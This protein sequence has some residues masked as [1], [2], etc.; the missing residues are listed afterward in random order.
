MAEARHN[1]A[2]GRQQSRCRRGGES[3]SE[4]FSPLPNAPPLQWG[5]VSRPE[6]ISGI[7]A[8]YRSGNAFKSQGK[9]ADAI[10]CYRRAIALKPD[11]VEALNNLGATLKDQGKFGEAAACYR[12]ALKYQPDYAEAHSNLGGVFWE[13]GDLDQAQ[14]CFRQALELKPDYADAHYNLG[15]SAERC[16]AGIARPLPVTAGPCN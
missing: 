3:V 15:V 7:Q 1:L 8:H 4:T 14:S 9:F 6:E 2:T 16:G 5:G 12:T 11:Y 10:A 13:Q